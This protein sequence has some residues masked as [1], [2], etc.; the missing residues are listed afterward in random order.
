MASSR[1]RSYLLALP[2]LLLLLAQAPSPEAAESTPGTRARKIGGSG[3]SSVFSLFNLK[4]KSK[5]WTE[6]VIRTEFDDL[7][8]S[9]SRDSSKKG[10]LNFTRAGN[11][12]SYMSL[13]EVDSIY[14]PIPVNFIFIGFDGKGGHEFKL[15]PEE[16]ERWFTKID[17]IFEYTRIPPVGE[18]LTPFYKT[19]IKKLRQYELPLVSHV[20]HNFSVHAIHMGEDVL[21][22]F[23]HAIKVLSRREDLADSRENEEGTLQVDSAQMEHVF[24]TLVDHLQIQEAYNIFILNPKPISKSINYGYRKGFSESEINLL[25]ENKTLQARILQSKRDDKLFLDIEKGVNRKPLYESHPLSSFSWASTDSMDMGDW[26]KKC[27][28]ALSKFERLKEGKSKDDIVYDKAVQI[29]HGTKDEMH[30]ILDNA[31]KSSGLKGL[32][33]ECLTDIW[34]GRERFAFVDL[35]AGPFAWGPSVGGDGVRTELSLPNV[36]KTVGAVAVTEEEAEEKLQDTIRERFSSFGESY[37]AVDILLAEIDVYELFAFKHCVG[38]RVQL[39]LCKELDERMHDLKNELEGYNTGDSD[40]INKKKALDALKRMENWNLFRDTKE[41]HHSYTVAHDSFLAQLGSMLWGSMRHV[42]A[43]SVSH[44][45]YH[46]YE[47][48]S[49]QLYFVTQEKVRSIKQLPVNVKSIT[50]SLNSVLLR[51]QKSMFSQQMLSLSDEPALMMAFSMA[52]RAAAVPLLLVNGTY[53]STVSTYLDSAILQHQLQK[54][55]EH[56]S[57][58]GRHSNHRSTL[59]VPI[60]WFIHSEPLLLDKHYQAKAL[61]NMVV[62]VQSDDDSWESHLQCNGR[63]ILWDLRKPVKAAIAATAEYISGL[64]PSH[65]VYSHAH[66]TAVEDWTWSVGCNPLSITSHGWQLSEFQQDAIGRNYI[67]TSVEESIQIVN[68]AIQRLIT[69]RATEKGFKIFKAH[70]SLMIEK[71]NAVVSLWRRVSA[72]SKGLKYGDMVKLMSMLEDA[73]HGFSRAVNSTISSL[74]PVQ[75]TRERKLDVQLDSTTLPAFL[76]VFLLLWFLLRPRRPKPKIN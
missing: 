24:S 74:H 35:S 14:L 58:K 69:E 46:Y 15:G 28:E 50:E 45:A 36:A 63:S 76:A 71:Y 25:R 19:T 47:K 17:H 73:S 39:A 43:P 51:H 16:L 32:H 3:A 65:L 41:E 56:N 68:S 48:L 75:C 61:S 22:V 38:R 55:S 40:E 57:F 44:R 31:L 30:D 13:A 9:A 67:I 27:K 1:R 33:A 52:R 62:V 66:E 26:S 21:S 20:N 23:E 10:M 42:I 2:L 6:S 5:F 29:L 54:L 37:H 34:I 12:A 4:A 18:V 72:M 70:E 8:G 7:E 59:E 11:I 64:L 53:K 60:F 49:F